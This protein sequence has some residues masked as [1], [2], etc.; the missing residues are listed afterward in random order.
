MSTGAKATILYIEDD[1]ASRTLV[2]RTLTHAG[3]HVI[4]AERGL[5]GIDLARRNPP[6]LI[7][8]DINLPDLTGVEITTILRA[9]TRFHTTPIVALTALSLDEQ[10]NQAKAAGING[11]ITKPVDIRTLPDDV[12]YYLSENHEFVDLA[13]L[14][15]AQ[16]RYTQGVVGRLEERIRALEASNASL[17]RL[18]RMKDSFI[19]VTAHELRTPLTLVY[20]YSRLLEENALIRSAGDQD[21]NVRALIAGFSEAIQRMQTMINEILMISRIMTDRMELSLA[22]VSLNHVVDKV[23]ASY[24]PALEQRHLTLHY[25]P[26]DWPQKIRAD[27]DLLGVAI[28]GLISNAI[29]YTPDHGHIYITLRTDAQNMRLSV[30]DT[31][32]GVAVEEQERIFDR[33]HTVGETMLHSTSKTAFRGGG[34]GLGLAICR[35]I[36]EAHGGRVWVESPGLD[37]EALPGSEFFILLPQPP[38]ALAN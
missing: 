20:G 13:R 27:A 21:P 2:E 37:A 34:L 23:V 38:L 15:E 32:I 16:M 26:N 6:D 5:A 11:Y 7:L 29:K 30:R 12:D 18:D 8:I 9:D 3:Y 28:D 24:R 25:D 22:A 35:G 1:P 4:V 31:G 19:H 36:I 33:F 17:R 10:R 14:A